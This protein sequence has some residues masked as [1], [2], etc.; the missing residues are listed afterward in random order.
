MVNVSACILSYNRADFLCSAIDSV[1]KQTIRPAEI[2]IF[3]NGSD[4]IVHERVRPY[5]ELG[6]TWIGSETT[7]SGVWNFQRA[8]K[9]ARS[10]YLFVL[11]D[12]D[13][14]CPNFIEEQVAI[15][16]SNQ[17]VGAIT[18][19]G[20]LINSLGERTGGLIRSDFDDDRIELYNSPAA[21]AIR[22]ASDSC[23]PFSPVV[24][25]A[26][27][28]RGQKLREEFGKVGDA[29]F[30][31]DLAKVGVLA[32]QPR[33]LYECRIH[34]AQ[35]SSHFPTIEL[36]RLAE[37]FESEAWGSADETKKLKTLLVKQHTSR[38][39]L[40]IYRCL[41]SRSH[42]GGIRNEIAGLAHH[43]FSLKAAAS[44]LVIAAQKRIIRAVRLWRSIA[45][46]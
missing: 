34:A 4:S 35:D 8:I 39:L 31:C 29:V 13:R 38:Q 17:V 15:L 45:H 33:P 25:R 14:L 43:R 28:L 19:N 5:L 42:I 18:C 10:E 6:A 26:N 24:Y 44:I 20:Y 21:I 11:H 12:D 22:Y 23:L 1:L 36:E 40:K 41:S 30:F 32:Y 46:S 2:L 3:D 27:F 7:N 16:Q 9:T 37:Y